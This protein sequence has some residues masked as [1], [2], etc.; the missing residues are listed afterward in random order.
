VGWRYAGWSVL[1]SCA[2]TN[3]IPE[4]RMPERITLFPNPANGIIT[5]NR[6][7]GT[8][9]EIFIT[10]MLGREVYRVASLAEDQLT[11]NL[12]DKPNGIYLLHFKTKSEVQ[13][14]KII[15]DK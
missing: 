9:S 2:G 10:D 11:I 5:V 14:E 4:K 1:V 6:N 15:L 13:I 12:T 3:S 7:A 8:A